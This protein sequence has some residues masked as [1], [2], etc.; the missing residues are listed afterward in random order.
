MLEDVGLACLALAKGVKDWLGEC[1][2]T[3]CYGVQA[4]V[5]ATHYLVSIRSTAKRQ[6]RMCAQNLA[7]SYRLQR[8]PHRRQVLS[9]R[10]FRV[11]FYAGLRPSVLCVF[12]VGTPRRG[13]GCIASVHAGP[14]GTRLK[15]SIKAEQKPHYA[16]E[17][18]DSRGLKFVADL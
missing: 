5:A 11:A 10:F 2:N 14:L 17:D 8:S 6:T 7:R 1:V 16:N 15:W 9:G 18:D 12:S 4:L 13:N 3:I